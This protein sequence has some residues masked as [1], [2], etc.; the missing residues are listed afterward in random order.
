MTVVKMHAESLSV[1]ELVRS[2][3]APEPYVLSAGILPAL[4]LAGREG[5]RRAAVS[6]DLGLSEVEVGMAQA[7]VLLPDGSRLR[8][9]DLD[10]MDGDGRC[11]VVHAGALVPAQALSP[12]SGR[13]YSLRATGRAPAL[14]NSG[15]PMH[16]VLDTTPDADARSKVGAVRPVR[17]SVL[18]TATGLGYTA[19]EEAR[20][21]DVVH[22]FE[23]D[24]SVLV[25]ARVN[26]WSRPLFDPGSRI[27]SHVADVTEAISD[28]APRA[29]DVIVHDPPT[30]ALGGEMYSGAFYAQLAR[31]VRSRG[32]LYHYVGDVK[33]AYGRRLLPGVVRRLRDAGFRE[34]RVVPGAAGLVAR[35]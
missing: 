9:E 35:L 14:L 10:A 19:I 32:R 4:R 25:L 21:A 5:R 30:L 33:S 28:L 8:W 13:A 16:R 1:P 3:L 34:V 17:G 29:F 20:T 18:D 15:F 23:V 2:G 6:L 12:T 22:T 7:G 27:V 24:P 11:F 26:P 31:V